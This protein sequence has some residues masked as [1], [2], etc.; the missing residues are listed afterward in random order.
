VTWDPGGHRI[1]LQHTGLRAADAVLTGLLWEHLLE[2]A[3]AGPDLPRLPWVAVFEAEEARE[4]A[5]AEALRRRV[6]AAERVTWGGRLPTDRLRR[7][8]A[9]T[10]GLRQ[11][12]ADL[13]HGFDAAPDG[14]Q[15]E[16]ARWAARRAFAVSGLD[17]VPWLAALLAE[18]ERGEAAPFD[19]PRPVWDRMLEDPEVPQ[20]LVTGPNGTPNC[21]QQ[22]MA[23][24]ALF[25]AAEE[26]PLVGAVD[27][28]YAAAIAYGD[29]HGELFSALRSTFPEITP[30]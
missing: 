16:V 12:D 9:N 10:W 13:L 11:L 3:A 21:L 24:P 27:A 14:R 17:G 30:G 22:A 26:D 25:A 15:R 23:L 28:L 8:P 1:A 29:A 7:L 18:V 2:R 6:E 4:R 20:T 19:D 5:E